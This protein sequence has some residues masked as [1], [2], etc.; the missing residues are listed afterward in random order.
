LRAAPPAAG[1]WLDAPGAATAAAAAASVAA[2][3]FTGDDDG[4]VD[5][6]DVFMLDGDVGTLGLAAEDGEASDM[7]SQACMQVRDDLAAQMAA[8]VRQ[9]AQLMFDRFIDESNA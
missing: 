9:Q 8:N 3:G 4:F 1:Q 2:G 7:V 6:D 5:A